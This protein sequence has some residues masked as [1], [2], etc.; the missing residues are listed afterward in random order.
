MNFTSN[1]EDQAATVDAKN[2]K[3]RFEPDSESK[4]REATEPVRS[5]AAQW[6]GEAY[7]HLEALRPQY[8]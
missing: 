4:H 5:L 3:R 1:L 7:W 8:R 6:M 2:P